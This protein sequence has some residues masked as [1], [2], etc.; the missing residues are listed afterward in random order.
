M[1]SKWSNTKMMKQKTPLAVRLLIMEQAE[2]H[3]SVSSTAL[4]T[5]PAEAIL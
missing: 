3:V 5:P 2:A 4:R 1:I